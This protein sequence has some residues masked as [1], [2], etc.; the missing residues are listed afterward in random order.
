MTS[1]TVVIAVFVRRNM[2][3]QV[4]STAASCST[5][6]SIS[7][8]ITRRRAACTITLVATT[9]AASVTE[10]VVCVAVTALNKLLNFYLEVMLLYSIQ[11]DAKKVLTPR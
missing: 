7:V 2:V 9:T 1:V 6:T 10:A 5:V 4:S 11:R 8:S 3:G